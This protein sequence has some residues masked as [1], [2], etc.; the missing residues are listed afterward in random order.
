M[1]VEKN[2]NF[3]GEIST[4]DSAVPL[5]C[6]YNE[7]CVFLVLFQPL[8][9]SFSLSLLRVCVRVIIMAEITFALIS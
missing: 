6:V 4:T 9:L 3:S 5:C 8:S 1:C 2:S 7:C